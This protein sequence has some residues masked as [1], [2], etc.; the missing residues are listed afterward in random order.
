MKTFCEQVERQKEGEKNSHNEQIT[1]HLT[2][3]SVSIIFI[4]CY[5]QASFCNRQHFTYNFFIVKPS[6]RQFRNVALSKSSARENLP[7]LVLRRYIFQFLCPILLLFF[8]F[9]VSAWQN[10]EM[11]ENYYLMLHEF[12]FCVLFMCVCVCVFGKSSLQQSY[13]LCIK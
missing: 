3:L 2:R 6:F 7:S 1:R 9:Y 10:F 8:S 12:G 5:N 11:Y 13:M 4:M